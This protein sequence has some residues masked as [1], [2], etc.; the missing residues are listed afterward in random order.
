MKTNTLPEGTTLYISPYRKHRCTGSPA[1]VTEEAFLS[2]LKKDLTLIRCTSCGKL[3]VR[4]NDVSAIRNKM[5]YGRLPYAVNTDYMTARP[6]GRPERPKAK[7]NETLFNAKDFVVR[8][9][10]FNCARA[11]HDIA[12]I[13]AR[14]KVLL[15]DG[16]V[17]QVETPAAYCKTCGAYYLL[18]SCYSRIIA[19]G[20]PVCRVITEDVFTEIKSG[21]KPLNEESTL[22]ALGYNVN[23]D[24][25]LT[26]EQRRAILTTVLDNKLLTQAE[27]LS[28]LDFLI[29]FSRGNENMTDAREKWE[30]DRL[31]LAGYRADRSKTDVKSITKKNYIRKTE[32]D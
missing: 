23:T 30:K 32:V 16:T 2:G 13:T 6:T 17:E 8:T 9:S 7:V 22:H 19:K 31:F 3:F 20:I 18:E 11:G 25:A 21:I 24:T 12:D 10:V 5:R 27:I 26:K 28:H 15:A 14:V 4:S 1:Y 29:S